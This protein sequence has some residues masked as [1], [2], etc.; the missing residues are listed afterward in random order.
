MSTFAQYIQ[1]NSPLFNKEMVE[2][3]AHHRLQYA[4]KYLDRFIRYGCEGKTQTHLK[5][6]GYKELNPKDAMKVVFSGSGKAKCDIAENDLYLVE[7]YFQYGDHEELIRQPLYVPYVQKGNIMYLSGG[8][9]LVMPVLADKVVSVGEK[10]IFI[11]II[12]AKYSFTRSYHAVRV[13][14]HLSRVSLVNSVL[15][16]NASQRHESTTKAHPIALHY[17]LAREGYEATM[18][19]LLGF[20]PEV[21]FDD[22]TPGYVTVGPTGQAPQ[23]YIGAKHAYHPSTLRFR[24]PEELYS[25]KVLYVLG[26]LFYVIDNFVQRVTLESLNSTM[27]WRVFLGEIIHSGKYPLAYLDKKITAHFKDL[28]SRFDN[29]TIDKLRDMDI[30]A[31]NLLELIEIIFLNF[32]NWIMNAEQKT[33]YGTKSFEVETFVLSCLTSA[34]NRVL[35]DISKEELHEGGAQLPVE[36]VQQF[37][38]K[39]LSMRKIFALRAH[40]KE[41]PTFF[42]SV[43]YCGD[44]YYPKNTAMIMYQESDFTNSKK[45]ES[46]TTDK[47]KLIASMATVGS[48]LGLSKRNPTPL[49]RL[50]PYVRTDPLNGTILPHPQYA[51]I[52]E[53]TDV[54]LSN[55]VS[56]ESLDPELMNGAITG[57]G[58]EDLSVD[59]DMDDDM[60][61]D[62]QNEEVDID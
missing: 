62:F 47:K 38:K 31:T 51:D 60:D 27:S 3:M 53:R 45:P 50:N 16:K 44:H 59:N 24:I 28:E 57:D 55:S 46:A 7:F 23:G 20:V 18:Q 40:A 37:F 19:R 33:L 42:T 15:Y 32:N 39:N 35:L 4:V 13:D 11:N 61:D 9:W 8:K 58:G 21:T 41:T 25:E 10:I 12:T 48:I 14:G 30:Q 36:K 34:I 54:L 43:D 52:I 5:Y 1:D 22:H 17:L 49:V 29:L 56:P 2:G 26:N 6:V